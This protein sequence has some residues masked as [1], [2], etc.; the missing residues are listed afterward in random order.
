MI[1]G[2]IVPI[3]IIPAIFKAYGISE[4]DFNLNE[5]LIT[6]HWMQHHDAGVTF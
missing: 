2:I 3:K 4:K 6:Y 1:G 5:L